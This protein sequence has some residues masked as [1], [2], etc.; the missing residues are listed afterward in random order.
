[1]STRIQSR[2]DLHL[3]RKVWHAGMGTLIVG[4]YLFTGMSRVTGVSIL[5]CA[6]GLDLFLETLRLRSPS[7]NRAVL[8]VWAPFIRQCEV[9]RMSGTPY[10]IG[11]ACLTIAIFPKEIAALSIL[12]LAWGDPIAS[13][14]GVLF[15]DRSVRFANGKSLIGTLAGVIACLVVATVFLR[16]YPFAPFEYLALVVV[17]GLA[18]GTAE[19]LPLEI[20]D[21]FSIPTVSGFALWLTYIVLG[22]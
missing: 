19:M 16:V 22:I 14:F 4:L 11:A 5:A 13:L 9:N 2:S 21:N 7:I 6:L 3:A 20:D 1:M 8:R 15:G 10:Y 18:G 17:A 12:L